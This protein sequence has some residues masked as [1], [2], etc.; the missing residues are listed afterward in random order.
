MGNTDHFLAFYM[1]EMNPLSRKKNQNVQPGARNDN[2][3]SRN[4]QYVLSSIQYQLSIF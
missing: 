3:E 1:K 2:R 4:E